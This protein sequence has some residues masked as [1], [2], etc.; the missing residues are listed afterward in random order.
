MLFVLL[1]GLRE[2]LLVGY[3]GQNGAGPS[4]GQE[5]YGKP[6]KEVCDTTKFGIINLSFLI[7]FF[8]HRNKGN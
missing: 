4:K 3:W 2:K 8:D 5:G 6:L 7:W 1:E